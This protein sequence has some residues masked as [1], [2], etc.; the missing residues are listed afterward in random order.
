MLRVLCPPA[1]ADI[2]NSINI[3]QRNANVY[4]NLMN[5]KMGYLED[6]LRGLEIELSGEEI[7]LL[8]E[9]YAPHPQTD[10]FI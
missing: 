4:Q 9:L 1:I 8:E 10:A 2:N 3:P 7:R 5:T 6:A